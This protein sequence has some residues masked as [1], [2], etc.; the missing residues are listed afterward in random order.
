M[1]QYQLMRRRLLIFLPAIVGYN[2]KEY[3]LP[4]AVKSELEVFLSHHNAQ[5]WH[6]YVQTTAISCNQAYLVF[7]LKKERYAWVTNKLRWFSGGYWNKISLIFVIVPYN[8]FITFWILS[9]G[10]HQSSGLLIEMKQVLT[11]L[12]K[13]LIKINFWVTSQ[14]HFPI[15]FLMTDKWRTYL[16]WDSFVQL[17]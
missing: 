11:C 8:V 1:M 6:Q 7:H 17:I 16:Y 12:T 13:A 4:T 3:S 2:L 10:Q 5:L 9:T 14:I 15:N